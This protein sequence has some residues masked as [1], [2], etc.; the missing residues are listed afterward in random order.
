MDIGVAI[1][2]EPGRVGNRGAP[3]GGRT[4]TSPP[5]PERG[6]GGRPGPSEDRRW[7]N[8]VR[9]RPPREPGRKRLPRLAVDVTSC[10]T[11][12]IV[13]PPRAIRVGDRWR[14]ADKDLTQTDEAQMRSRNAARRRG[15]QLRQ[16]RR[17]ISANPDPRPPVHQAHRG[18]RRARRWRPRISR[19]G[20]R[21]SIDQVDIAGG[22]RPRWFPRTSST[23]SSAACDDPT[24]TTSRPRST[25]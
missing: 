25:P 15:G 12:S 13:P 1:T 7:S 23:R 10:Y 14:R 9:R 17:G 5:P 20:L 6:R 19:S 16:R 4:R 8:Y 24:L 3:I 22:R 11:L 18:E 2:P 21:L